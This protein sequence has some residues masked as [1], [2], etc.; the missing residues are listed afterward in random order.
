MRNSGIRRSK[1]N[2][3]FLSSNKN[4]LKKFESQQSFENGFKPNAQET[5]KL[6]QAPLSINQNGDWRKNAEL[7]HNFD[8]FNQ[9]QVNEIQ[10]CDFQKS[11]IVSDEGKENIVVVFKKNS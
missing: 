6:P 11:G 8:S 7:G 4:L 1:V 3:P 5:E 10:N 2:Q 9:Q